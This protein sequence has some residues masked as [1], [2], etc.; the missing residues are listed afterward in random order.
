MDPLEKL[1]W[2][3]DSLGEMLDNFL[4]ND[5]HPLVLTVDALIEQTATLQKT[6]SEM[7]KEILGAIGLGEC[8]VCT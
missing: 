1:E 7:G 4:T 6:M 8:N 2:R 5:F 3:I